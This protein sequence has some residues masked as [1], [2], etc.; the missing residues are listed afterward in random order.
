MKLQY[1]LFALL[2]VGAFIT[3]T[4]Q[5]IGGLQNITG[6]AVNTSYNAT[7][8]KINDVM[9]LTSGATSQMKGS[10][11]A[12][13]TDAALQIASFPVLKMVLNSFDLVQTMINDA[14]TDMGL[15]S[16]I[17]PVLLSLVSIALLFAII[18]AFF[19][20]ET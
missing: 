3:G 16:W 8:D 18:N 20:R 13:T 19:G 17:L 2:I 7:Y 10:D 14:V 5:F 12:T 1:Y 6:T 15:P 9:N 4:T 11:V